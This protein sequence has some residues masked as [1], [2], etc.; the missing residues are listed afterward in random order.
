M[1]EFEIQSLRH[2]RLRLGRWHFRTW[3]GHFMKLPRGYVSPEMVCEVIR[4]PDGE[5]IQYGAFFSEAEAQRLLDLLVDQGIDRDDLAI[6]WVP[7][8][9]RLEDWEWDR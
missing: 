5:F 7:V 9:T 8:H 3:R 4:E 1:F 6:N 2:V